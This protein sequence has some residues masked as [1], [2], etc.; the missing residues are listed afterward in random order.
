MGNSILFNTSGAL[1][2]AVN[3]VIQGPYNDKFLTKEAA[4]TMRINA[5]LFVRVDDAVL[6]VEDDIDLTAADLD[7]GAALAATA[8][9][10]IYAC[11][12]ISGSDPDF[13]IS[14]NST[15]PT[16]YSAL[17]SRKIGGFDT[18]GSAEI[19]AGSVWDL[20]TVD[21]VAGG[22]SDAQIDPA[23]NISVSKINLAQ[24]LQQGAST[25]NGS[26]GRT[27]SITAVADTN[28][29]VLIEARGTSEFIGDITIDSKTT[30]S[31]VVKNTGSD[32]STAFGWTLIKFS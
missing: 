7:V 21:V 15:Y 18:D 26:S 2:L 20:R 4:A 19:S 16:G 22:V 31:F 14:L 13:V 5:E 1:A 29:Q 11:H 12:P 17:S 30:N 9:Y 10:Y 28:Y 24:V 3:Y 8:T 27:I 25:F 6:I 32:V 23:A